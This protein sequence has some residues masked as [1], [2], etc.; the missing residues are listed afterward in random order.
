M[1]WRDAMAG[2]LYGPD[3]FF[4]REAPA[5]HFRTSAHTGA[6]WFAALAALV[7]RVDAALAAPARLDLVDV[8]AGRGE[9]LRGLCAALPAPVRRRLRPVAVERAPRP[10][11]LPAGIGWRPD[12]PTG[13][14]GL[15][16]AV[17]WLDNVPLD[18]ARAGRY[19]VVD[20]AGRQSPGPPL[21]TADRAWCARW[22]PGGPLVEIGRP[23]DAAW[24]GAVAAV[25][26]GLALAVDYGHT[27]ADRPP[28]GTLTGYRRGRQVP[29]VPDGSCDLTAHVA[30]D[31]AASAAG[32]PFRIVDQ[33]SALAA[34]GVRG[35]RPPLHLAT[36]DP[37][38]YLHRLAAASTAAELRDPA[39][40]GGQ[41]WLLHPRGVPD[42]LS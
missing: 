12:I 28:D 23:R 25:S 19:T 22:W 36:A 2:A 26:R 39:G 42:P 33:R 40:L 1:R 37:R 14:V 13:L 9:L 35:D 30:L 10:P 38:A 5:D 21:S 41:R 32:G 8:G 4:V 31:A 17:E 29:P 18:V 20:A 3:G 7:C 16:V 11:D 24:A 15:L 34:L 6:P 27:A